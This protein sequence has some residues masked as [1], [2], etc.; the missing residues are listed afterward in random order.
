MTAPLFALGITRLESPSG[1]PLLLL[2]CRC[3]YTFED[4][5][6]WQLSSQCAHHAAMQAALALTVFGFEEHVGHALTFTN[7]HGTLCLE[8]KTCARTLLEVWPGGEVIE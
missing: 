2:P 8:C 6:G 7:D 1:E 4:M 3:G 5:M